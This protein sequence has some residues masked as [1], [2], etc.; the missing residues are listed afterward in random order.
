MTSSSP[1]SS[2]E[3]RARCASCRQHE[4]VDRL[5]A[6][7]ERLSGLLRGMA[8]RATRNRRSWRG[9]NAS[10]SA[11]RREYR[12]LLRLM[13]NAAGI[14]RMTVKPE[15]VTEL[16]LRRRADLLKV[17]A[18]RDSLRAL[19]DTLAT[20]YSALRNTRSDEHPSAIARSAWVDVQH[21]DNIGGEHRRGF[22]KACANAGQEANR[23]FPDPSWTV[24]P[25]EAVLDEPPSQGGDSGQE[26]A[27]F[28][29]G[30]PVRWNGRTGWFE[31]RIVGE[32]AKENRMHL[33]VWDVEVTDLGTFY[34]G[35]DYQL[36]KVVHLPQGRLT[37]LEP[38]REA[39]DV[40]A[41]VTEL[42]DD[43]LDVVL[44]ID[45]ADR[46]QN[47]V[48][49]LVESDSDLMRDLVRARVA[50]DIPP[51]LVAERMGVAVAAVHALERVDADPRLSTVRRYALA[52][53]A[54]VQHTVSRP[55]AQEEG[56]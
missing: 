53:G 50:A 19:L 55:A 30:D 14:T 39:T 2:Q 18:E 52:V 24:A 23:L 7:V 17:R 10:L 51:S 1:E 15:Q 32:T 48:C 34:E 36:G 33:E 22:C 5:T 29:V 9:S 45:R 20:N 27:G 8:R 46:L 31:G 26:A 37:L 40:P 41:D 25:A 38:C 13:A 43:E 44:G 21:R 11:A 54:L 12:E 35:K 6:E 56:R 47:L 42:E 4:L 28:R 3:D 49:K 16:V